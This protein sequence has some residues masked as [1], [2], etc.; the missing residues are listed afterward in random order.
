MVVVEVVGGCL[1]AVVKME[2]HFEQQRGS[3]GRQGLWV[4]RKTPPLTFRVT[5]GV[6][7]G[8]GWWW[9]A[10]R[11]PPLVFRAT[12]GG[13]RWQRVVVSDQ[14]DPSARVSSEGGGGGRQSGGG[15]KKYP[16]ACLSSD[17]GGGGRQR[18]VVSGREHPS[19]RVS[20]DRGGGGRQRVAGNTSPLVFRATEGVVAG[21]GCRCHSQMLL[22]LPSSGGTCSCRQGLCN[23]VVVT[24]GDTAVT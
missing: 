20:S 17:G 16:S 24:C 14:Q 2:A 6:V 23:V 1:V 3:G 15:G 13:G 11:T 8:K 18:V 10:G 4:T 5:E 12:E 21:R 7:A 9:V 19:T 22:V